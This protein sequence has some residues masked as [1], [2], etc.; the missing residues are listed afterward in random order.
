MKGFFLRNFRIENNIRQC[1]LAKEL[2]ISNSKLS[3]YEN[4]KKIVPASIWQKFLDIYREKLPADVELFCGYDEEDASYEKI[5][6]HPNLFLKRFREKH[7]FTQNDLAL[8][9]DFSPSYISSIEVGVNEITESFINKMINVC[10][11]ILTDEDIQEL[12]TLKK[13]EVEKE[14]IPDSFDTIGSY[15]VNFR[16]TYNI[17]QIELARSLDISSQFLYKLEY[18]KIKFPYELFQKF[19]AIYNDKITEDDKSKLFHC[20]SRQNPS[21]FNGMVQ[22]FVLTNDL[23]YIL[24]DLANIKLEKEQVQYLFLKLLDEAKTLKKEL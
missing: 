5:S 15:L 13:G 23:N 24:Y 4:G 6:I 10:R 11:D 22:N 21:L 9:L 2:G 7:S 20:I 3:M 19:L 14:I 16:K 8:Q 1:V 12:F 17:K 18:G